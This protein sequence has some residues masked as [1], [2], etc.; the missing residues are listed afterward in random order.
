MLIYQLNIYL[1]IQID[2]S[3]RFLTQLRK[4][5]DSFY[6]IHRGYF[7]HPLEKLTAF[8][9]EICIQDN[10]LHRALYPSVLGSLV[11]SI[12]GVAM[13]AFLKRSYARRRSTGR[14]RQTVITD[15]DRHQTSTSTR[16]L[17]F[18]LLPVF[19]LASAP[20]TVHKILRSQHNLL[21][22]DAIS[23]FSD[24]NQKIEALAAGFDYCLTRFD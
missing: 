6:S 21:K 11:S 4:E 18:R 16:S 19:V 13:S 8:I 5:K 7:A 9:S 2:S 3:E 14:F 12:V 22:V 17:L 15:H 24:G 10:Q 1:I 23:N 20:S